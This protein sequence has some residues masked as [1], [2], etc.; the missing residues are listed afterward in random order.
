MYR[1]N[2]PYNDFLAYEYNDNKEVSYMMLK[3]LTAVSKNTKGSAND[4]ITAWTDFAKDA[5]EGESAECKAP[6][7][8][9]HY[10]QFGRLMYHML[11]VVVRKDDYKQSKR[12]NQTQ[13]D[14][15]PSESIAELVANGPTGTEE[16]I[17]YR[18]WFDVIGHTDFQVTDVDLIEAQTYAYWRYVVASLA[19][20]LGVAMRLMKS[21][22]AEFLHSTDKV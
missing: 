6:C 12:F 17:F 21:G 7:W 10:Q 11:D 8:E 1:V 18:C 4:V 14:F 22:K 20:D 9:G 19:I 16:R 5:L 15:L 13:L 2:E 3:S